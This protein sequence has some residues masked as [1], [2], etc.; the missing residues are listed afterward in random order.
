M[1]GALVVLGAWPSS[2]FGVMVGRVHLGV[3]A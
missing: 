2:Q 3:I 1:P